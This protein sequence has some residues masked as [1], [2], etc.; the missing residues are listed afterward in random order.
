[1]AGSFDKIVSIEM[2][3]AVG[4]ENW[5]IYYSTLRDRLRPGGRIGLQAITIADDAFP[6]YRAG[7]DFIQRYIFPG[8]L[9]ASPRV[10]EQTAQ[11]C[12]LATTNDFFF[13]DSY[14]ETMRRWQQRFLATWPEIEPLGF[15]RRFQRM[16]QYYLS[17][18]EA[19][20]RQGHISVGQFVLAHK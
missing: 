9:L 5:P 19:G 18:C 4:E 15:D 8:G 7:T 14:A 13:G 1:M 11:D 17:Y 12:G 10:M 2:F 20:F 6:S 16:W 3:E